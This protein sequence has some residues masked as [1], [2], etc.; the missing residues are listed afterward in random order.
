MATC[1]VLDQNNFFVPA[2]PAPLLIS[3]CQGVVLMSPSEFS[4]SNQTFDAATAGQFYTFGL[5]LIIFAYLSGWS[6][7][8]ILKVIRRA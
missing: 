6:V 1:A 3:D 7:G 5:G 2:S 4:V 8:V